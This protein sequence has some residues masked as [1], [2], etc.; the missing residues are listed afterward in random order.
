MPMFIKKPREF[1]ARRVPTAL[2]GA[3][4]HSNDPD[5]LSEMLALAHW[6]N[7]QYLVREDKLIVRSL[8]RNTIAHPG[9]WIVHEGEHEF[10]VVKPARFEQLFMPASVVA[11]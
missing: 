5:R 10:V 4:P 1:E 11:V 6:C 2:D 3:D 7:G 9:D 8:G